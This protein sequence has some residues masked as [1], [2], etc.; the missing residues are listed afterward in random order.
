VS[1]AHMTEEEPHRSH[2]LG[3]HASQDVPVRGVIPSLVPC[4]VCGKPFKTHS[5]MVRHRDTTHH[6]T[7]G[8]E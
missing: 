5:E 2:T 7:K 8:H 1:G 3:A 6:E 4:S